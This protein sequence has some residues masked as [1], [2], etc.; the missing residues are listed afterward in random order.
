MRFSGQGSRGFIPL[1]VFEGETLKVFSLS[2]RRR[3]M[4]QTVQ[5]KAKYGEMVKEA[6]PPSTTL[7]N[8]MRAF[9]VGGVICV[10][11]EILHGLFMN[12][13]GMTKDNAGLVTASTLIVIATLLTSLRLYCKLGAFAG[14]GSIVP[15]TGFANAITAPAIEHRKEGLVLGVGAKMFIIAGPVIVYGTITSVIVGLIY[16]F[17]K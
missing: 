9:L 11:G 17:V 8:C 7:L 3:N 10:I 4:K 1:W 12:T 15:I 16:Y 14:A 13:M 6:S 5:S 2:K